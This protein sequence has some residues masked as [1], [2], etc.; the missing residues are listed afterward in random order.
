MGLDTMRRDRFPIP[1]DRR[2]PV[3]LPRN[4]ACDA[5]LKKLVRA[6]REAANGRICGECV[7]YCG[8]CKF[9]LNLEEHPHMPSAPACPRFLAPSDKIISP[10]SEKTP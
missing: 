8:G 4:M 2:R 5:K 9:T 6:I 1:R 10:K 3:S 7:H